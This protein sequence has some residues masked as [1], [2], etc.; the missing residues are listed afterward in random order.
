MVNSILFTGVVGKDKYEVRI[1][2]KLL[3]L[4][5][6]LWNHSPDGFCWGYYGSGP[7]QLALSIMYEFAK[8][9]SIQ[10]PKD[11]ADHTSYKFKEDFIAKIPMNANWHISGEEI[12]DWL[13]G[14]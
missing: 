1:N 9:T 13:L 5:L 3:P 10:N 4:R 11:F 14:G 8:R 7:T 6:N 2:G 12:A